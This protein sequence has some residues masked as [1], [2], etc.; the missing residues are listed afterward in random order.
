MEV[1]DETGCVLGRI[2]PYES[3]PPSILDL[4]T[5]TAVGNG[6]PVIQMPFPPGRL[7]EDHWVQCWDEW[8]QSHEEDE[9]DEELPQTD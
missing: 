8:Y 4:N 2:V 9:E 1:C 6:K 3:S 7:P 5:A